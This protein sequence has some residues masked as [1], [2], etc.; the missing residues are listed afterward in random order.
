[1]QITCDKIS[2]IHMG[3]NSVKTITATAVTAYDINYIRHYFKSNS[4]GI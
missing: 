2:G 3:R 1:M 4:Q